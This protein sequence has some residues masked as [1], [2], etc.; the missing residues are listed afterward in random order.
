M[1]S[2][3]PNPDRLNELIQSSCD[4]TLDKASHRELEQLLLESDAA[5][6]E[7]VEVVQVW[8]GLMDWAAVTEECNEK[9]LR[10][11]EAVIYKYPSYK[12]L[13]CGLT[14]LAAMLALAFTFGTYWGSGFQVDRAMV[15][16]QSASSPIQDRKAVK[17]SKPRYIARVVEVSED[18]AWGESKPQEFLFRLT[19]GEQLELKSGS[20]RIEFASGASVILE[21]PTA[22]ET[23]AADAGRLLRGRITGHADDGNFRLLTDV[24][25]VIDLGTEFGVCVD[26]N[27]FIDV[28]VFDGEVDVNVRST[29]TQ[30]GTSGI[31]L[32]EGMAIRFGPDGEINDAT[33]AIRN[34]FRRHRNSVAE[35]K[36]NGHQISLV[37][38][39]AGGD[40]RQQQLA[41]AIDQRTGEWDSDII[42]DPEANRYRSTYGNYVAC[43]YSSL[44][45][46]VFTPPADGGDMPIDSSGS[47]FDFGKNDGCTWGSIWSRRH[48][49]DLRTKA[50][51]AKR[52]LG[53]SNA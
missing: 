32:T 8:S 43:A 3:T 31:R 46:G 29:P 49:P 22:F 52:F 50:I 6:Q 21:G 23:I 10:K 16:D 48:A 13:W 34:G 33:D 27:S 40:G 37:D 18:A 19:K 26:E 2:P 36:K 12:I 28:C 24:A 5:A 35:V 20:A 25:D 7:Y 30:K 1:D 14:S 4:E 47:R 11:S 51:N 15:A 45:D 42:L 44:I 17:T 41:G 39:V 53:Y 38:I 9:V